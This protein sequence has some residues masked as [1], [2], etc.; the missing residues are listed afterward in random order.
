[1]EHWITLAKLIKDIGLGICAFGLCAWMIVYFVKNMSG[2]ITKLTDSLKDMMASL[3][4]FM[5]IVK[6]EH[7]AQMKK[8]EELSKDHREFSEQNKEITKTLGRINGFKKEGG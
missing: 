7:A 6:V 8:T 2:V 4:T 5:T 1:M 3:K